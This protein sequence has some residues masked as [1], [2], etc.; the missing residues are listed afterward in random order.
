MS[1]FLEVCSFKNQTAT[2][3]L[4]K[5]QTQPACIIKHFSEQDNQHNGSIKCNPE[6]HPPRQLGGDKLFVRNL[7]PSQT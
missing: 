6:S 1:I 4:S 5:P 3:Q 7:L 2:V